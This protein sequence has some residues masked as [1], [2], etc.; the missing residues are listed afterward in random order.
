MVAKN[1]VG[2]TEDAGYSQL[3]HG[4]FLDSWR[5]HPRIERKD[6]RGKLPTSTAAGRYQILSRTWDDVQKRRLGPLG[7]FSPANQDMAVLALIEE[8]GINLDK[9]AAGDIDDLFRGGKVRSLGGLFASLPIEKSDGTYY[10]AYKGQGY[11]AP[12]PER[13]WIHGRAAQYGGTLKA[14]PVG[15][16]PQ[17]PIEARQDNMAQPMVAQF[18]SAVSG[19]P[20]SSYGTGVMPPARTATVS[21]QEDQAQQMEFDSILQ[22]LSGPST[23]MQMLEQEAQQPDIY[24]LAPWVAEQARVR[25]SPLVGKSVRV[26]SGG[27]YIDM[28][29]T[30]A[31]I[32]QVADRL[33]SASGRSVVIDRGGDVVQSAINMV[34]EGEI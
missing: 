26:R 4:G 27:G 28:E 29:V 22:E 25:L 12:G 6:P 24:E 3:V 13:T 20:D 14:A 30:P 8:R 23:S 31:F 32:T 21:A 18:N 17:A 7:D 19:L 15:P 34:L 1:E 10:Y 2:T 9:V 5:D 33:S 16:P 11:A